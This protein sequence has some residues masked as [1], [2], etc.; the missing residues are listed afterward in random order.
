[1]RPL[2]YTVLA[3]LA[4]SV[5][6]AA[7]GELS[8]TIAK[9]RDECAK[10]MAPGC[11]ELARAELRLGNIEGAILHRKQACDLGDVPSCAIVGTVAR[12]QRRWRDAETFLGKACKKGDAGACEGFKRIGE[13]REDRSGHFDRYAPVREAK[14]DNGL[15]V[16][17]SPDAD[18]PGALVKVKVLAGADRE[19]VPGLAELAARAMQ[20]DELLLPGQSYRDI[21]RDNGV[22]DY[23]VTSG[24]T[25]TAFGGT[26]DSDEIGWMLEALGMMLRPRDIPDAAIAAARDEARFETGSAPDWLTCAVD[27]FRAPDDA[28]ALAAWTEFGVPLRRHLPGRLPRAR[29]GEA[30]AFVGKHY[31]PGNMVLFVA[32][33]FDSEKLLAAT[34]ETLGK[35][36]A[37][38]GRLAPLSPVTRQAPYRHAEIARGLPAIELGAKFDSLAPEDEIALGVFA[39]ALAESARQDGPVE[40]I[41]FGEGFGRIAVRVPVRPADF[42]ASLARLETLAVRIRADLWSDAELKEAM[43]AYAWAK[44]RPDRTLGEKMATAEELYRFH[45]AHATD[46]TPLS[47]FESLPQAAL[48]ARLKKL[49]TSEREWRVVERPPFVLRGEGVLLAL[50]AALFPLVLFGGP[51]VAST[52]QWAAF[53]VLLAVSG[54]GWLRAR[55]ALVA[56]EEAHAVIPNDILFRCYFQDMLF[57]LLAVATALAASRLTQRFFCADK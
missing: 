46:R 6:G 57:A 54:A 31:Y 28:L 51:C 25:E 15:T 3:L 41:P 14:L 32:G 49:L 27:L 7:P 9:Y 13:V 47:V 23:T 30:T 48:A 24:R 33:G 11:R 50:L 35:L 1:M 39:A 38:G 20:R 43:D 45:K 34:R 2:S 4:A 18:E 42:A 10:A 40:P 29:A 8:D 56:W 37:R 16:V 36:P 52:A 26:V 5:A 12:K 19:P 22:T 17:M 44:F 53:L 21:L 55:Q